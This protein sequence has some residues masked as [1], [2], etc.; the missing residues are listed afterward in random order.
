MKTSVLWMAALA[1]SVAISD[2]SG[3]FAAPKQSDSRACAGV[4][5]S[6]GP[7]QKQEYAA[8]VTRAMTT[9]IKPSAVKFLS[10]LESGSWSAVYVSTP[11]ADDGMFFF[12]DVDGHKQFKEVWGGMADP[13][14]KPDLTKWAIKLGAPENLATCF[15]D[16]VTR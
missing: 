16:V 12:Q 8:L 6:P 4:E 1:V 11:A 3:A 10:F 9:K 13:S 7:A 15:A 2:P 14:E 5:K